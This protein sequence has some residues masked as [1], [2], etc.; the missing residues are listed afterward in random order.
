MLTTAMIHVEADDPFEVVSMG[1]GEYCLSIGRGPRSHIFMS[2]AKVRELAGAAEQLLVLAQE[3][4][5]TNAA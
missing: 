1:K 5:P 4:E 3:Q 2:A